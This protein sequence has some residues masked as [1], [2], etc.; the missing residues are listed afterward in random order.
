MQQHNIDDT[1]TRKPD[2][3]K[4]WP[5]NTHGAQEAEPVRSPTPENGTEGLEE[6]MHSSNETTQRC[7][8]RHASPTSKYQLFVRHGR[9]YHEHCLRM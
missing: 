5:P 6:Q 2:Q 4:A 8:Q 1:P 7:P 9:Q 3:G